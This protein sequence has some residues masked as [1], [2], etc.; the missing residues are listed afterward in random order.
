MSSIIAIGMK[1]QTARLLVSASCYNKDRVMHFLSVAACG[2]WESVYLF[3]GKG[4]A[5]CLN[6]SEK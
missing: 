6:T 1:K 5:E 2:N 4:S 3:G